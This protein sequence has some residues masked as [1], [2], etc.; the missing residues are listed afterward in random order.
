MKE[1]TE[2]GWRSGQLDIKY[3]CANCPRLD[4]AFNEVLR[5]NNT[6]AAVRV[7]TH[8]TTVGTKVLQAGSTIVMPFQQ[9]HMNENVWGA[10]V[11]QFDPSRF[12]RTKSWARHPSFR[13]FGGGATLCPGQ[14]LARHEV[15]G[16]VAIFVKRFRISLAR[17]PDQKKPPF[18]Q[19]NSMA[20]SFGL[21]GPLKGT[22]VTINIM[23]AD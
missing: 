22:D 3:L 11:S 15:F 20:P 10:N 23:E 6:A 1:E 13:P 2:A 7:A 12:L 5:L 9:L 16:F 21:N 19:L 8:K 18:P 17:G 4:A 14:T